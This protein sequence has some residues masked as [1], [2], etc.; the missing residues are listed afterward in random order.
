[1]RDPVYRLVAKIRYR[2]FG[3]AKQAC[4]LMPPELRERFQ[5]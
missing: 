3:S 1:M 4:P 5:F 2:L